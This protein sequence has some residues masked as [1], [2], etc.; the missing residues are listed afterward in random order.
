M[1]SVFSIR[2]RVFRDSLNIHYFDN[3][4]ENI[5]NSGN[6]VTNGSEFSKGQFPK[7]D[8]TTNR[9]VHIATTEGLETPLRVLN[10]FLDNV[11]GDL[12]AE[13]TADIEKIRASMANEPNRDLQYCMIRAYMRRCTVQIN[14]FEVR[15]L[16]RDMTSCLD[17]LCAVG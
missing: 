17:K 6:K 3:F 9:I 8:D 4:M 11:R 7:T 1:I 12:S 13:I 5:E 16:Y 15:E 14:T 2:V 10:Y